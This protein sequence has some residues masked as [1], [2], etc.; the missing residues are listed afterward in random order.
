M[1]GKKA[2]SH[3]FIFFLAALQVKVIQRLV[4]KQASKQAS[5]RAA[6]V[7]LVLTYAP[8]LDARK[9]PLGGEARC[10]SFTIF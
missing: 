1:A 8:K 7:G 5:K 2:W 6:S 4:A 3:P 10:A 9:V